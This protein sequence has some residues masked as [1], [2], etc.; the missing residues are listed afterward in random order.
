MKIKR[1]KGWSRYLKKKNLGELLR[2][3]AS[4]KPN[5]S[6]YLPPLRNEFVNLQLGSHGIQKLIDGYEFKTILDIGC[7]N[8]EH[9]DIFVKYNK[10]VTS[11]DYGDSIYFKENKNNLSVVIADF[12]LWETKEKFDA[13]WCSHVLE[14]QLNVNIFLTQIFHKLKAEGVLAITVPPGESLVIGGHLTN[15]NAGL[16]LHNLVLAG[17]DCSN[18]S[19]LQYGYNI[20][21]IVK[22]LQGCEDDLSNLSYDCGDLRKISKYLPDVEYRSTDLDDPF[23][24]DIY[25]LNW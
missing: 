16:L 8:G 25:Q 24:G 1:L 20:T 9:S 4:G 2:K 19:V 12:N 6:S 10:K 22:K 5:E 3:I 14:H 23:N 7:G 17:F 15:W 11:I 13:V 18:A 21:I